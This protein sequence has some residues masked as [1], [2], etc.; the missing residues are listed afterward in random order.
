MALNLHGCLVTASSLLIVVMVLKLHNAL[1]LTNSSKNAQPTSFLL[2]DML[3]HPKPTAVTMFN[4][5]VALSL[6][7]NSYS[8]QPPWFLAPN[9]QQ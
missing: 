5:H 4:L 3:L 1:S 7:K 8:A 2:H 6:T 9:Q